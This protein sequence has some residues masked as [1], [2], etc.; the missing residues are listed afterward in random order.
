VEILLCESLRHKQGFDTFHPSQSLYFL[1]EP[2]DNIVCV[3]SRGI[4]QVRSLD[5]DRKALAELVPLIDRVV[6]LY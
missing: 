3:G 2:T 5:D 4:V 6:P 1:D